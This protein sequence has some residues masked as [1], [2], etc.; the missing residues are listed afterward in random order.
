MAKL[1]FSGLTPGFGTPLTQRPVM[2]L[3]QPL[4]LDPNAGPTPS[5]IPAPTGQQAQQGGFWGTLQAVLPD[6]INAGAAWYGNK[7]MGDQYQAAANQSVGKPF[8]VSSPYGSMTFDPRTGLSLT[9]GAGPGP[10]AGASP[11]LIGAFNQL[12]DQGAIA[13]EAQ[14]RLGLLR[15]LAAPEEQRATNTLTN[16][17]YAQ[18]RLGGTGGAVQQEALA[19]AQAQADLQRQ[20]SSM[21]WANQNALQRFNAAGNV[22]GSGQQQQNL[23]FGQLR[24][25]AQL[26]IQA[27]R[28]PASDLLAAMAG[29]RGAGMQSIFGALGG[30]EEGGIGGVLGD[31]LFGKR[32]ANQLS[33]G[34]M[35]LIKGGLASSFAGQLLGQ[36]STWG[37]G[38]G[39]LGSLLAGLGTD[40]YGSMASGAG[41][42]LGALS[43]GLGEGSKFGGILG[44]LGNL[45]GGIGSILSGKGLS[46]PFEVGSALSGLGSVASGLSGALGT[47]SALGGT[48]GSAG[49]FLSNLGGLASPANLLGKLGGALSGTGSAAAGGVSSA[50]GGVTSALGPLGILAGFGSLAKMGLDK[51]NAAGERDLIRSTERD[52]TS[53]YRPVNSLFATSNWQGRQQLGKDPAADRQAV[54]AANRLRAKYG[55]P[56]LSYQT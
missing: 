26:G 16:Q 38:L 25:L 47:G 14:G 1:N 32:G 23:G 52:L 40:N 54:E 29:A 9:P 10:W 46:S 4:S 22:V 44:S 33:G 56:P 49:G 2:D 55:Q 7:Q 50:L 11:E 27:G 39:G 21:D 19:R 15:Q 18:G 36:D 31:I 37:Q 24:D 53:G 17:L 43:K 41:G 5:G 51:M 12:N 42:L 6:L 20:L 13:Q 3:F 30:N 34:D 35:N 48:L 45:A 28:P 8:P